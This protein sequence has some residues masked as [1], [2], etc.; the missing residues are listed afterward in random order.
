MIE[1]IN[2]ERTV[3]NRGENSRMHGHLVFIEYKHTSMSGVGRYYDVHNKGYDHAYGGSEDPGDVL[4]IL[5]KSKSKINKL[6]KKVRKLK[7]DLK[8]SKITNQLHDE[9]TS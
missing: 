2:E 7:S 9:V 6:K 8:L 1:M 5:D 4:L 3:H